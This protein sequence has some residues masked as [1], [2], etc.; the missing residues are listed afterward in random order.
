MTKAFALN[1]SLKALFF[2]GGERGCLNLLDSLIFYCLIAL[3]AMSIIGLLSQERLK[4]RSDVLLPSR[5][6]MLQAQQ[7]RFP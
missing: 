5:G 1:F 6:L 2:Y 7:H 3:C 4:S